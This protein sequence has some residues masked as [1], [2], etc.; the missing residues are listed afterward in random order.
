MSVISGHA[1]FVKSFSILLFQIILVS[2]HSSTTKNEQVVW[3]SVYVIKKPPPI[4]TTGGKITIKTYYFDHNIILID[5]LDILFHFTT[6]TMCRMNERVNE[7]RPPYMNLS[8]DD[9]DII[10]DINQLIFK[11]KNDPYKFEKEPR[12]YLISNRDTIIDPRYFKLKNELQPFW[13][14]TRKPTE[15]EFYILEAILQEKQHDPQRIKWK[16]TAKH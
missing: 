6:N 9:F 7:I 14:S 8:P 16:K 15:E 2:C 10:K 1:F 11:I 13:L 5:T 12:I 4:D 3:D